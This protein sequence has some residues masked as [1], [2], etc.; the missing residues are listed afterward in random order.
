MKGFAPQPYPVLARMRYE[1]REHGQ[2]TGVM[3]NAWWE[4][5]WGG[6]R[7]LGAVV[8][9]WNHPR[10]PHRLRLYL[11]LTSDN[12]P[13]EM[14]QTLLRP[15]GEGDATYRCEAGRVLVAGEWRGV[16]FEEETPLPEGYTLAPWAVAADGLHFLPEWEA[17]GE[18]RRWVYATD[19]RYPEAPLLG[20]AVSFVAEALGDEE[21]TVDGVI[22]P[23]R[24]F[25][26]RYEEGPRRATDYWV[27]LE[28]YVARMW[29]EESG[30]EVLCVRG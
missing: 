6:G 30:R 9:A 27:T 13:V 20:R 25:R 19:P 10:T 24:R 11:R 22:W 3:E 5:R 7:A 14:K 28:G 12:A 26:A 8:E 18:Q 29:T 15:D 23:T 21:M 17:V 4:S 1:Y 2:L 16:R